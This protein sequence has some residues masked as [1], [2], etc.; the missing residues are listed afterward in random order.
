[1]TLQFPQ[2]YFAISPIL[3]QVGLLMGCK[4]EI[5]GT[6]FFFL[7]YKVRR[8]YLPSSDKQQHLFKVNEYLVL[9]QL[10]KLLRQED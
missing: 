5:V 2:Y 9:F 1:M 4:F 3:F 8:K 7:K 10:G 6:Q